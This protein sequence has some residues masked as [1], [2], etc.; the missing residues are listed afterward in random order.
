MKKHILLILS[1]VFLLCA[2]NDTSNSLIGDW[3]ADKVNVQFDENQSTPELVKQ[4]GE[5]ERQNRF[6][7]SNDSILDFKGLDTE[8][9][10]RLTLSGNGDLW[11]NGQ[12]FGH[13]KEGEIVTRTPSPLGEIVIVYK[14]ASR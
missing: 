6:T 5:M 2:C 14:K 12:V 7:I 13:W 1:L 11:C 9:Q 4:I 10:S 3:K 8:W